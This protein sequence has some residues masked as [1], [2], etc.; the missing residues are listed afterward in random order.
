MQLYQPDV[1]PDIQIFGAGVCL[2]IDYRRAG[3]PRALCAFLIQEEVNKQLVWCLPMGGRKPD[4]EN[5]PSPAQ[6]AS[7]ELEEELHHKIGPEHFAFKDSF[8]RVDVRNK[9]D[10]VFKHM[11]FYVSRK[12]GLHGCDTYY[13]R[14]EFMKRRDADVHKH[15]GSH[16]YKEAVDMTHVPVENL[17]SLPL[18]DLY[19]E[20]LDVFCPDINNN[21]LKLRDVLKK[22]LRN[23]DFR[24]ALECA[25]IYYDYDKLQTDS[26]VAA[27]DTF[28]LYLRPRLASG[29][30]CWAA[31]WKAAAQQQQQW[32]GLHVTLCGFAPK[33][34]SGVHDRHGGDLKGTLQKL[35]ATV[36]QLQA[37]VQ[38]GA[39]GPLNPWQLS[40]RH[41]K[42]YWS[43]KG[44]LVMISLPAST[45]LAAMSSVVS[46]AQMKKARESK[47]LHL[48]LGD[49][50]TLPPLPGHGHAAFPADGARQLLPPELVADLY[51]ARWG[52]SIAKLAGGTHPARDTEEL[53]I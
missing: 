48:T 52:V 8:C 9:D 20:S 31:G 39:G 38:A 49:V 22:V 7:S 34:S 30:A 5:P 33:L 44:K 16:A 25:L 24:K 26:A 3:T 28:A 32:G 36:Q 53:P 6:S 29:T 47:E 42:I 43:R 19:N 4:I 37:G 14:E 27:V 45:T 11:A 18:A 15:K 1:K 2:T 17:L 21:L 41:G 51:E 46:G 23:P 50:N 13:S 12:P 40:A 35:Q 10:K